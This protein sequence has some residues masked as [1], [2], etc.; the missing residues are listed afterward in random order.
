VKRH[1]PRVAPSLAVSAAALFVALGGTAAAAGMVAMSNNAKHLGRRMP[2]YYLP[3]RHFAS[4]GV[5]FLDAGQTMT[6]GRAGPF[7][8]TAKC[9][10]DSGGQNQVEFDVTSSMT[11]DLDGGGVVQPCTKV[12]I[13]ADSDALDSNPPMQTLN[14]GDFAQVASASS[15]TEIASNPQE[16]D[17]FYTDGVNW[18]MSAGMAHD[19]FAGFTG[20]AS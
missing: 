18:P 17:I 20:F 6:V 11:A 10:K 13:H 1:S 2:S 5:K 16:V 9:S 15:S 19:C 8:F 12:T 7:T 3:A 4:N 14:P